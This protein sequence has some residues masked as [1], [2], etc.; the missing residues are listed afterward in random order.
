MSE[1]GRPDAINRHDVVPDLQGIAPGQ[2]QWGAIRVI[3]LDITRT[4]IWV[5]KTISMK[6]Y[7]SF[8]E[9]DIFELLHVLDNCSSTSYSSIVHCY[10][11]HSGVE[12]L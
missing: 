9:Q 4:D 12:F 7:Y 10:F 5:R 6:W 11:C 2:R 1:H 8:R 3:P